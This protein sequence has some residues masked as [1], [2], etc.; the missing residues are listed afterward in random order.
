MMPH[1]SINALRP[2]VIWKDID[3]A[4]TSASHVDNATHDCLD[5]RQ[6]I[7]APAQDTKIPVCDLV[8][9]PANPASLHVIIDTSSPALGNRSPASTVPHRYLS[10]FLQS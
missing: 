9:T 3:A 5:E 10:T 2:S 4:D 8:L 7:T 1:S 6:A